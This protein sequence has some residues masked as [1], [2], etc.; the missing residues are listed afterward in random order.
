MDVTYLVLLVTNLA[1]VEFAKAQGNVSVQIKIFRDICQVCVPS[2]ALMEE[3]YPVQ[4]IVA[5]AVPLQPLVVLAVVV[6]EP[7]FVNDVT[8][9]VEIIKILVTTLAHP[10]N[11]G[12]I[13]EDA[14]GTANAA[15]AEAWGDYKS[16][17]YNL[18]NTTQKCCEVIQ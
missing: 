18:C 15:F 2:M 3:L 13:A 5:V 17:I 11:L 16:N 12:L 14:T 8:G 1:G 10:L 7:V 6:A 9:S 4:I